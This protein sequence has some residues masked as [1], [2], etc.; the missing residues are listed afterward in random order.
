[1]GADDAIHVETPENVRTDQDLQPLAVAKILAKVADQVKPDL[2]ITGKQAIDDDCGQTGQM[3]AGLLN[4]P[5]ATY[6]SQLEVKDG[7][8]GAKVTREVEGGLEVLD[9]PFPAVMTTDLR[10]NTPRYVTLPNIMKARKKALKTIPVA[11]LGVD[12]TPRLETVEVDEPP[13]RA[14]GKKIDSVDEL[15]AELKSK[16]LI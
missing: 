5:Q 10:L 15:V 14:A 2:I 11:D 4:W 12:I 7:A 13:K 3:L 9:V 1:M 16:D 8:Q 6:A